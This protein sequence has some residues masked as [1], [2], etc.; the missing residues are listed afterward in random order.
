MFQLIKA[1]QLDP[2]GQPFIWSKLLVGGRYQHIW[3]GNPY[4]GGLSYRERH[5][6]R[7]QYVSYH[8]IHLQALL[9]C[10]GVNWQI[11]ARWFVD[12][13]KQV[14]MLPINWR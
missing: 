1:G 5:G 14:V 11:R 7:R 6:D 9:F 8:N 10:L 3:L 2:S 12:A 4:W 13:W